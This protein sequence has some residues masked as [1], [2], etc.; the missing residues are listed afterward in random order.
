LFA[1]PSH[2]VPENT[3]YDAEEIE[4]SVEK[5]FDNEATKEE[6]PVV[7]M[8][9]SFE[10][11]MFTVLDATRPGETASWVRSRKTQI[12]VSSR[13]LYSK[14]VA[15]ERKSGLGLSGQFQT[16]G[17]NQQAIVNRLV[18]EKNAAEKEPNATWT[19]FGVRKNYEEHRT[20]FKIWR[21]NNEIRV[22]LK[23]SDKTKDVVPNLPGSKNSFSEIDKAN[24]VDLREPIVK[25]DN[26]TAPKEKEKNN[27]PKPT[28][29][30]PQ[31]RDYPQ[32]GDSFGHR[33]NDYAQPVGS[34]PPCLRRQ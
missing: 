22:I 16:L 2:L 21:V 14:A 23:R 3:D 26:D 24:I 20:T 17:T 4:Q 28:A 34:Y 25:K 30:V 29:A 32:Y 13:E 6:K 33:Q 27:K 9:P 31:N 10:G 8:N 11:Y 15:H 12:P 19:L 1:I 7:R 18:A 5:D